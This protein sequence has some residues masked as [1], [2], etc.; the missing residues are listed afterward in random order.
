MAASRTFKT[1]R[2]L[3]R[4]V[5]LSISIAEAGLFIVRSFV[6]ASV[7]QETN[8]IVGN[9]LQTLGTIYAVLLAFVVFVVWSQFNETRNYVEREANELIDLFRTSK[10]LPAARRSD[11]QK[12]IGCYVE[13]VLGRE[14][15]AMAK[16]HD[17][18]AFDA[19]GDILDQLWDVLHDFEPSTN[20]HAAL[21][22]EI[23]SRF[24]DL[25]DLRTNRLTSSRL[26]IPL[27]LKVLIYTGAVLTVGSMYLFSIQNA[28]V[29]ALMTGAMAG[30]LSHILYLIHELDNCFDGDWQIPRSAFERV[31][32]F[33]RSPHG[34]APCA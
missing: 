27:A 14:W 7:F 21:H 33:I 15:D 1:V 24:N 8:D 17:N 28:V 3:L 34:C 6:P 25:S 11:I 20:C 13:A 2:A 22:S 19:A 23:L 12:Y 30:A 31:Q 18:H 16:N 9:Y 5:L 10:G 26:R 29:H 32:E 4:P